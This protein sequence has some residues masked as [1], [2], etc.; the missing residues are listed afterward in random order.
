MQLQE[1]L[2]DV[3]TYAVV[4]SACRDSRVAERAL[5]LFEEIRKDPSRM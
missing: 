2:P 3:I 1:L 5:Q 4:I